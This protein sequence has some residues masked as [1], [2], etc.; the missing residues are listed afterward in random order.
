MLTRRTLLGRGVAGAFLVATTP[1]SLASIKVPALTALGAVSKVG[2]AAFPQG[3][4][5][6]DPQPDRLMLWT[7]LDRRLAGG[8]SS[9]VTLQVAPDTAFE[10]VVVERALAVNREQDYTLRVIVTG[11]EADTDYFYRFITKDGVSSRVG[12]TW[13]APRDDEPKRVSVAFAS[14]QGYPPRKYGAYRHLIESELQNPGA[15]PAFVLHLGD[16]IY[17]TKRGLPD[18]MA[19]PV[20]SDELGYPLSDA[21]DLALE[22][23]R[24]LYRLF[25]QD[26]D[27][28]DAR[29]LYPFI[30]IWDDHEFANDAWQS[31]I[32]GVGSMPQ[33]RMAASQAWFEYVPQILAQSRDLPGVA[34]EAYDYHYRDV[35]DE[36]M[37]VFGDGFVSLESN[38]LAA[39]QALA[40]YRAVRWGRLLDVLVTD[41][42]LYRGPGANPGYSEDLITSGIGSAEAFSK[43][44]LHQG[45]LL[46]ALAQ[47][48]DANHG[49]PPETVVIR[50]EEVPN[51]RRDS[52]AVS[53][54]GPQQ[55][56]WLKK[57]LKGSDATWKVWANAMP[58]MA[59]KFDPGSLDRKFTCG[60]LWTDG[61]D[62]F[63]NERAE[64]MQYLLDEGIANVVSLSGD[65]HAHY[66]GMVAVDYEAQQPKYVIPDFT[67]TAISAF[68]RGPFLSRQLKK[69]G[70]AQLA[71]A[72]PGIDD[73][74]RAESTLNFFMRHG[75]IAA[76]RLART[77]DPQAALTDAPVSPNPHLVYADNNVNGYCIARFEPEYMECDFVCIAS[78]ER[79]GEVLREG[80]DALRVVR[81]RVEGWV[82]G[83]TPLLQRLSTVGRAPLGEV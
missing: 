34:N 58:L 46:S 43:F 48:R 16:Y 32:A 12:R 2:R 45:G 33:K 27:L 73:P 11:L 44:E 7:R 14:C 57:A 74:F 38:N 19:Q 60:Y 36:P 30:C 28:Q 83:G 21:F 67:C 1:L 56:V 29:A 71:T 37:D 62:G 8:T 39:I 82:G 13:T 55:K 79:D 66:A 24:R 10:R 42:R 3:V 15:R 22:G 23:Q 68:A 52:P 61:W 77:G 47:G 53:M 75:A 35:Q 65:R 25:L 18:A 80:P 20:G 50:G 70:L 41:N 31:Y 78:L 49:A 72:P 4:G 59:F 81:F 76:E 51:P 40:T 26:E 69:L 63:P 5:S 54:L 6:A 17:G 9:V 64:L